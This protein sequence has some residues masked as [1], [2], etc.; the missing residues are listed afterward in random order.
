M[1]S[2]QLHRHLV[3][4]KT[5]V[6]EVEQ[7]T[8]EEIKHYCPP[9]DASTS[10]SKCWHLPATAA[11]IKVRRVCKEACSSYAS[12][13]PDDHASCQRFTWLKNNREW[14]FCTQHDFRINQRN[15]CRN[16]WSHEL[17][18]WVQESENNIGIEW[19]LHT[20]ICQVW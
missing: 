17:N 9:W 7:R 8:I 3:F 20:E 15:S 6:R 13:K 12:I 11:E 18:T 14:P 5:K 19:E 1:P 4:H 2:C 10:P 16:D